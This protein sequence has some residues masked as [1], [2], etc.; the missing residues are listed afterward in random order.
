MRAAGLLLV[1]GTYIAVT[2]ATYAVIFATGWEVHDFAFVAGTIVAT[3]VGT[4]VW[5][6]QGPDTLIGSVKAGLGATLSITAVVCVLVFQA[7][8]GWLPHP[9]VT[10]FFAALGGFLFPFG[11]VGQMWKA[12]AAQKDAK[13]KRP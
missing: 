10:A 9:E 3:Q 7:V 8:S 2:L 11:L 1:I 13:S 5:H 6:R 4:L 12:L